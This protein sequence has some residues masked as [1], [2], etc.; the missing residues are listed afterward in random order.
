[1]KDDIRVTE[2]ELDALF[3]HNKINETK[4]E[5]I[6]PRIQARCLLILLIFVLRAVVIVYYPEY[7]LVSTYNE[8]LLGAEVSV[9]MTHIRLFLAVFLSL[10]YLFS[11]YKNLFFSYASVVLLIVLC[12]LTWIDLEIILLLSSSNDLMLP[13][14]GL[15]AIKLVGVVLIWQNFRDV[16]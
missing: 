2:E 11:F 14:L 5:D 12:G 7:S 15:L 10:I 13:S 4:L 1:M 6:R 3:P 8:R 16:S 9:P